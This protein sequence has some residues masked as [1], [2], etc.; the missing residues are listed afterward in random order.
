MEIVDL[1]DA[2]KA[3][4][5]AVA[6]GAASCGSLCGCTA[7]AEDLALTLGSSA[8][9]L[10]TLPEGVNLGLSCGNPQELAALGSG[11]VVLELCSGVGFDALL[12]GRKVGPRGRV[13]GVDMTDAVYAKARAN[14]ATAGLV[15]VEFR[16]GEIEDLPL[17]DGS[18]DVALSNCVLNLVGDKDRALREIHR[19][20]RPGG[21]PAGSLGRG[22]G[23]RARPGGAPGP[24][25][26]RRLHRRYVWSWTIT[27]H[28]W[29]GPGSV[30][31][32]PSAMRKP[33]AR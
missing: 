31:S 29:S 9:D 6:E 10:A 13:I 19:V 2:V 26:S 30:R 12:A 22:L 17:E 25:G 24:G 23:R 32:G 20:L 7:N 27:W 28:A 14:A 4:S 11:Q 8:E 33:P 16:Q 3:G 21:G 5:I 15:H 1:K 18:T